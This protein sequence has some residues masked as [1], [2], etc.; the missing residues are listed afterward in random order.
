MKVAVVGSRGLSISNL[1][2]YLPEDTTEII[3]GGKV[4]SR[5][6]HRR[7]RSIFSSEYF[8]SGNIRE[9]IPAG[10]RAG[11]DTAPAE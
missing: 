8:F 2:A 5:K 3:S 7:R 9:D 1:E 6:R 4:I 10:Y 11:V